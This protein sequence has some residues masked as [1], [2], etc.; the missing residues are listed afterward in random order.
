MKFPVMTIIAMSL[1]GCA[2]APPKPQIVE[3]PVAIGCLGDTPARPIV[4]FGV[5][6]Y[7][8]DKVAAQRALADASEWE[9]YAVGL[10]AAMAGCDRKPVSSK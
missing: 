2:T 3:I 9:G 1:A 7:P 6:E 4:K 10:E 5:G 8:G